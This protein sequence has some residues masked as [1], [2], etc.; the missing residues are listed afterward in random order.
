MNSQFFY[1]RRLRVCSER[2]PT[3]SAHCRA[4]V[5]E[6]DPEVGVVALN[7]L[8]DVLDDCDVKG[9]RNAEDGNN[10]CLVLFVWKRRKSLNTQM[11]MLPRS[12][13]LKLWVPILISYP[14]SGVDNM[15]VRERWVLKRRNFLM[16]KLCHN[17]REIWSNDLMWQTTIRQNAHLFTLK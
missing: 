10:N 9:D 16:V 7:C 8:R 12:R 17:E 5:E 2:S 13:T 11:M 6:V 3:F 15:L 4:R 1:K 14:F